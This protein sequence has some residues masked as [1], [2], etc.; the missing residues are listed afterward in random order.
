MP[1][2]DEEAREALGLAGAPATT[3]GELN[4][5]ITRLAQEY[6]QVR[7]LSYQTLNDVMGALTGA[8]SE[9]Q[10]RVVHPYE[11]RKRAV[12]GDVFDAALLEQLG[13]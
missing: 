11:E 13:Q 1:Y 9:F 12:N 2:I 10:R 5:V 7:G 4:Y 8:L 6:V 3:P